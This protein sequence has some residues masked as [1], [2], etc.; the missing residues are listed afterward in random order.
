MFSPLSE[1]NR[2]RNFERTPEP[3]G[4]VDE[5]A[6]PDDTAEQ[7]RLRFAM[8]HHRASRDHYDL[9]L[10]WNGTLLSWAVPKGP[11]YNPRDKRLA[12]RVEDH[13]LDYRT[14]EG[15]I[16]QGEYG[17]GT[18]MLW[19]EG[20]WEPLVD[21]ED[22]LADGDL[23][24]VL[25]GHRLHGAWVLVHMKPKKGERDNNWLLIKEKDGYVRA[26]AGI[27]GFDTSVQTGRTMDEIAHG[28]DEAFAANPFDHVDVELAKLVNA[29]FPIQRTSANG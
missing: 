21:V 2:K 23:K 1:Y 27:D 15:V 12:V 13:P 26:D 25:D 18:V 9:R 29:S 6:R 4:T 20:Y 22:G 24:F 28:E 5:S 7:G 17:G 19:D 8:Q 3:P 14:F 11:S 16:A 10:E